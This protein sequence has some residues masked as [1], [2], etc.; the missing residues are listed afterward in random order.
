MCIPLNIAG[1][2]IGFVISYRASSGYDRYWMGRT[3]WNQII[4][5]S[6]TMS[7]LI[8][9]HVPPRLSPKTAE[10]IKTGEIRRNRDEKLKAMKEKKLAMDLIQGFAFAVKHHLR[11]ELGIYYQDL[12]PLVRP[13]HEEEDEDS[14][15]SSD[16]DSDSETASIASSTALIRPPGSSQP[17]SSSLKPPQPPVPAISH[18][19]NRKGHLHKVKSSVL[20][21][22]GERQKLLPGVI[23]RPKA[24][25][26]RNTAAPAQYD[27]MPF[28]ESLHKFINIFTQTNPEYII[29]STDVG[30]SKRQWGGV[31]FP[32]VGVPKG[33]P[34][35]NGTG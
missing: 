15:S 16:S 17:S 23:P 1:V 14:S 10:E 8:H 11:G 26:K 3:A 20:N 30:E 28:G 25:I 33:T 2:I 12:Y 21:S 9:F 27:M 6:R 31:V 29:A 18:P 13:L 4:L 7:R 24:A 5:T 32:K 35:M 19:R 22:T 34:R